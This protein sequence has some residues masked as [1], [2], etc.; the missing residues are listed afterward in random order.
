MNERDLEK[1]IL[2]GVLEKKVLPNIHCY[3]ADDMINMI[4]LADEF[5]FP[6]RAFHHSIEAYK[7]RDIL[8]QKEIGAITW[9]DWWGFKAEAYD[10]IME[11]LP[12]LTEAGIT[13]VLH[14]DSPHA[15]QYLNQDAAKAYAK[16]KAAGVAVSEPQALQ[17]ITLNPAKIMGIEKFTGSLEKGKWAD[18]VLWDKHPFS[19]YAQVQKV[20]INGIMAYDRSR[21]NGLRWSDF[22]LGQE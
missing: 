14:S 13:A 11:N 15:I 6:I 10:G 4:E 7:I 12:L 22:L 21:D 17:W 20:F 19:V 2:K 9:S 1:E 3:R 18:I 8:K 5:K 16:G